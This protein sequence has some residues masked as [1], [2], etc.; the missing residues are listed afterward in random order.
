MKRKDF[1]LLM[2]KHNATLDTISEECGTL[3]VDAPKGFLWASCLT[4]S[5][6][7]PFRNN[8]GQSWKSK[9][10]DYAAEWMEMGLTPC[11][12]PDCDMCNEEEIS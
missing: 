2:Q 4:H 6:C 5:I 3:D 7:S 8:G 9:A 10:Y 1:M 12:D 11:D